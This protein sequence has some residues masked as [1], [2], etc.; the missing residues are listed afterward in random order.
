MMSKKQTVS[1][2]MAR[3]EKWGANQQQHAL[4][5]IRNVFSTPR[6]IAEINAIQKDF[7]K[8]VLWAQFRLDSNILK[9]NP[10]SGFSFAFP[11]PSSPVFRLYPAAPS[12]ASRAHSLLL[13]IYFYFMQMKI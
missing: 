3:I 9:G 1:N 7:E 4:S 2:I 5:F 12:T 6:S 11:S 8:T 13:Q 10:E